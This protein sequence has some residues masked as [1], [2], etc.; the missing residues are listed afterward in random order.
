MCMNIVVCIFLVYC[1]RSVLDNCILV[2]GIN[3]INKVDAK[4]YVLCMG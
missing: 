2:V 4:L 1:M 3:F